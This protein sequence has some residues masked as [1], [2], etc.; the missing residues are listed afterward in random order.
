[1]S[2]RLQDARD[3]LNARS[4]AAVEGAGPGSGGHVREDVAVMLL[5]GVAADCGEVVALLDEAA[6]S[7]V[8][9]IAEGLDPVAVIRGT[10]LETF[11]L[12]ALVG[13]EEEAGA[14]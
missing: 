3:V 14:W 12:G 8:L 6:A 9:S 7:T 11:V 1:M 4:V 5:S 13:T 2:S 10:V